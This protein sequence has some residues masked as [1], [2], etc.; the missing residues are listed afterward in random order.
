MFFSFSFRHLPEN[1]TVC[2][3]R[4]T[5]KSSLHKHRL[6]HRI[7]LHFDILPYHHDGRISVL[8]CFPVHNTLQLFCLP[9]YTEGKVSP[10]TAHKM[11]RKYFPHT[12]Y[13]SAFAVTAYVYRQAVPVQTAYGILNMPYHTPAVQVKTCSSAVSCFTK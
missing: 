4:K 13:P 12:A 1:S 2:F 5:K 8:C 7:T 10:Y 3:P 6:P 11:K 9:H